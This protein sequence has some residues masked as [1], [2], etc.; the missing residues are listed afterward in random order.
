MLS[1]GEWITTAPSTARCERLEPSEHLLGVPGSI[2]SLGDDLPVT[3]HGVR[4]VANVGGRLPQAERRQSSDRGLADADDVDQPWG[5]VQLGVHL[6]SRTPE[7]PTRLTADV[8][9]GDDGDRSTRVP[10]FEIVERI[11][12]APPPV[13]ADQSQSDVPRLLSARPARRDSMCS[14]EVIERG[15]VVPD[16]EQRRPCQV[17]ARP[18]VVASTSA[19]QSPE[20]QAVD[21]IEL[22]AVGAES[23]QRQRSLPSRLADQ[24]KRSDASHASDMLAAMDA[25]SDFSSTPFDVVIAGVVG[26]LLGSIPIANLVAR[27]RAAI[28]LR[29]V[30]DRNPGFWNARE[31]LGRMAAVPVFV[32]DVTKGFAAA[33][34]GAL[35]A[36]DGVWGVA[37]VAG[38]AAMVGHAFPVF[39]RFVGG[40]SI[41]TFVGTVVVATPVATA[42]SIGLLL[43]VFAAS[44]SFAWAA[45]AG[46]VALPFVQLVVDGPHRTAATGGL[47]TFIGLRFA[48]AALADRRRVRS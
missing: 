32:G 48:A 16:G 21:S 25:I 22:Q 7:R 27:R 44:R 1:A 23:G 36:D 47:M 4:E 45:R 13:P 28:D 30:G 37:Y 41:L 11:D 19:E 43:V 6:A 34:L 18:G 5:R 17:R 39:A 42:L 38:G 8:G 3:R 40:R 31:T 2:T 14:L 24:V 46:M 29:E 20:V 33:G 35:L 26:Y 10:A 15:D 12:A 9:A